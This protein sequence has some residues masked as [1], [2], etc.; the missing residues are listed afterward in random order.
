M[1]YIPCSKIGVAF[2]PISIYRTHSDIF[3]LHEQ[4]VTRLFENYFQ[5]AYP[6]S[7]N[8]S[9]PHSHK[10]PHT[11]AAAEEPKPLVAVALPPEEKKDD[12]YFLEVNP[13]EEERLNLS[14]AIIRD[15]LE[16]KLVQCPL[17]VTRK[18]L[19]IL[20][21][22]TANGTSFPFPFLSCPISLS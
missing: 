19:R 3:L 4:L 1:L 10:P 14:Q 8:C 2:R 11:M 12:A 13:E 15:H 22:A 5:L 18:G 16:D 7:L 9:A 21:S 17:D 6:Y 20:D